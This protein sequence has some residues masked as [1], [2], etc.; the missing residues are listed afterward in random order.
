MRIQKLTLPYRPRKAVQYPMLIPKIVEL[1][2]DDLQH[3]L[4]R[5]QI[6]SRDDL[7]SLPANIRPVVPFQMS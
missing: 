5:K 4:I 6:P 1:R 2:R 3:Q 7:L